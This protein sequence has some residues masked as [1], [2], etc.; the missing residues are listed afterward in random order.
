RLARTGPGQS[1]ARLDEARSRVLRSPRCP[2]GRPRGGTRTPRA[3]ARRCRRISISSPIDGR[4]LDVHPAPR[5]PPVA[6]PV[7]SEDPSFGVRSGGGP[8][9]LRS[10]P[11]GASL[12]EPV[13][14]RAAREEAPLFVPRRQPGGGAAR[15]SER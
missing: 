15:R 1:G 10:V 12:L 7:P 13:E 9:G 14:G 3:H 4:R 11:V 8:G 5:R 6:P 2:L